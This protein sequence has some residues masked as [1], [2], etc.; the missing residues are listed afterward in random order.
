MKLAVVA[1]FDS[2]AGMFNRPFFAP[3][4]GVA[5]RSFTDEVN[6]QAPDNQLN[7]HP[8]DFAL[9]QLGWFDDNSGTFETLDLPT[10][11]LR[12]KDAALKGNGNAS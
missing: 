7:Q 1:V 8:E 3:A 11:V 2:A 5:L 9:Y 6:R 10:N 4:L 12:G